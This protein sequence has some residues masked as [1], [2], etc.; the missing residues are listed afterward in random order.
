MSFTQ[1]ALNRT[2]LIA[3][4]TGF[5]GRITWDESKPNGQPRRLLNTD[6]ARTAF[7]FE[8]R[9]SFAAGLERTIQWYR[10]SV[11]HAG[12][13]SLTAAGNVVMR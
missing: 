3:G 4:L 12:P 5:D 2:E 9:T 10:D 8:A 6:R 11:R 7:G 1:I 13:V